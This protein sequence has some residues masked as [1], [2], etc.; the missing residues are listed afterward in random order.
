[1]K[2]IILVHLSDFH[3]SKNNS[4]E[5][6]AILDSLVRDVRNRLQSLDVNE[7]IIIVSGDLTYSGKKEEFELLERYIKNFS[8]MKGVSK[9]F[10]SPGNHDVEWSS[11]LEE[12]SDLMDDL[13]NM[14][15]AGE[16]RVE[17]R[18]ESP[19]D[20][21]LLITGMKNYYDF[22]KSF[23]Q[24]HSD[25]FYSVETRVID[26]FKFN[27]ISL[28]SAFLFSKRYSYYGYIGKTQIERATS[29]SD[30]RGDLPE[31]FKV[32]NV[33]VFHHPLE[34]IVP[35]SQ[36]ETENIVKSRADIIL[37]GHVHNLKVY[38]DLTVSLVGGH[39]TRGHPIISCTRAV[40]DEMNNPN[41]LPGYSMIEIF[42][43][44]NEIKGVSVTEIRYDKYRRVWYVDPNNPNPLWLPISL[45][46]TNSNVNTDKL[47][48]VSLND[49]GNSGLDLKE[50]VKTLI[51]LDFE[52]MEGLVVEDEGTADQWYPVFR[53]N[54]YTWRILL[55]QKNEIAGY[56][57]VVPLFDEQ[58][59]KVKRGDMSEVQIKEDD[60]PDLTL[61]GKYKLYFRS[62]LLLE[63]YRGTEASHL[64]VSSFFDVLINL[65]KMNTF[66]EEIC[67]NA[68]TPQGKAL[69]KTFQMEYL[70]E[71]KPNGSLYVRKM[72]ELP[73]HP[74]I[75]ENPELIQRYTTKLGKD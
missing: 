30:A 41:V 31:Y 15:K 5:T 61:G 42:F 70:G 49:L 6:E 24:T 10:F 11:L 66:V 33:M 47:K 60:I 74:I 55:T 67:A 51:K 38:L 44:V 52:N 73:N 34:A 53:D 23:G 27:L 4:Y 57:H 14:G 20:R 72:A 8:E 12:D 43:D 2:K 54:P 36:I 28:N 56:W 25:Y 46:G 48:I 1:M 26:N 63:K 62:I 75:R 68:Y 71:H 40:Y 19:L 21:P 58:Y 13:Y 50:V 65:A 35:I 37:N 32:F 45:D 7:V 39:N 16:D 29:E 22:I 59:E 18:V 64:L 3:I 17:R 9:I 69:C